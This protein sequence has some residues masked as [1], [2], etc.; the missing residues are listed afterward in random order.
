MPFVCS[1]LD[2]VG[3]DSFVDWCDLKTKELVVNFR[4]SGLVTPPSIRGKEVE[5]VSEYK[6]QY[7]GMYLDNKLD[8]STHITAL[9]TNRL[10]F[11]GSQLHFA[12]SV[13]GVLF[14][15]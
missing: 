1:H 7:R 15:A 13:V 4:K 12:L 14:Y 10:W 11:Q 8:R 2:S 3:V 5:D 9:Y 6:H